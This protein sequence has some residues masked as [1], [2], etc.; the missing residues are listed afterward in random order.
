MLN[1]YHS[2][3]CV[4]VFP[5]PCHWTDSVLSVC[6]TV[7]TAQ[8]KTHS[9]QKHISARCVFVCL[10]V[11]V[12][13]FC[14]GDTLTFSACHRVFCIYEEAGL[15]VSSGEYQPALKKGVGAFAGASLI[16][17]DT[18]KLTR[19]RSAANVLMLNAIGHLQRF[20]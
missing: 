12:T 14:F 1:I 3:G 9:E 5:P 16:C 13:N 15:L 4:I 10:F 18:S 20:C 2:L 6:S 8:I 19:Q 11:F 17:S 7:G